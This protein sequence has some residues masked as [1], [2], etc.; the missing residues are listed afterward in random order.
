VRQFE[1]HQPGTLEE[2]SGLLA[3]LGAGAMVYAGGT[4]IIPRMRLKKLS[5][6]HLVNI[7]RIPGLKGIDFDGKTL[8]IGALARL[9]D[10]IFS[11]VVAEHLPVLAGVCRGMASHQVRNLA[12]LGGNLCNAAPSADAPPILIALGARVHIFSPSG[13]RE[14]SLEEFFRGPGSV[15]L[16]PGELL[17]HILVDRPP[18]EVR[19]AYYKHEIREALEIA[20]TGVAV[21]L[22]MGPDGTCRDARVVVAACAPT[23]LRARGAEGALRGTRLTKEDIRRAGEAAAGEISPIDD[24]RGSARYRREMTEVSLARAVGRALGG[25]GP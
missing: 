17:T 14:L 7:K 6:G 18:A 9:N 13:K 8:I 21:A 20:I 16:A 19:C 10:I 22:T 4:D 3:R 25:G 1:Y 12:T 5:P 15:A 23:P 2:A 11:P 24:V